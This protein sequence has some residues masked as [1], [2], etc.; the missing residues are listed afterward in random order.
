M[1]A[2]ILDN[3]FCQRDSL[4]KFKYVHTSNAAAA[5]AVKVVTTE[6]CFSL[7]FT[8]LADALPQLNT[9]LKMCTWIF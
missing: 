1:L 8:L 2:V 3:P 4:T 9:H 6:L 5:A 7:A